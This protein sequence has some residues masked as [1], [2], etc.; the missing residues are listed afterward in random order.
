MQ[1]QSFE[2]DYFNL[3]FGARAQTLIMI[4]LQDF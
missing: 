1:T 3:V 2:V 4:R